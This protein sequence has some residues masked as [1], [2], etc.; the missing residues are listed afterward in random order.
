[1]FDGL[2][3]GLYFK[4]YKNTSQSVK[5]QSRSIEP[6]NFCF[7]EFAACMFLNSDLQHFE[8]CLI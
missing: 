2:A 5:A 1:M 7:L 6:V 4:F 3:I 8:Q